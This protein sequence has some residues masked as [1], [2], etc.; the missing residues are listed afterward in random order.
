MKWERGERRSTG[1][2]QTSLNTPGPAHF[3][4]E[5]APHK[6]REEKGNGEE[7]RERDEG[8]E[9][10]WSVP[11]SSWSTSGAPLEEGERNKVNSMFPQLRRKHP[12][13][14]LV[15]REEERGRRTKEIKEMSGAPTCH[16]RVLGQTT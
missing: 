12:V 10:D 2:S 13:T 1:Q 5:H 8:A 7:E 16:A 3:V 14:P 6:L 11:S 15:V 4:C 9:T